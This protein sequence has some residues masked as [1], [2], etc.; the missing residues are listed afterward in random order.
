MNKECFSIDKKYIHIAEK[1]KEI[2]VSEKTLRRWDNSGNFSC[3]GR[4]IG[5]WRLY[6]NENFQ[7]DTKIVE[8]IKINEVARILK[9]SV[10]TIRRWEKECKLIPDAKTQGG[11]RLYNKGSIILLSKKG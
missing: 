2:G 3:D 7:K 6:E 5:G 11:W 1:A 10:K 8:Y 4:T 9:V